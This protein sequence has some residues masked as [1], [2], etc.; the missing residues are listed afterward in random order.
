MLQSE[1]LGGFIQHHFYHESGAGF[2]QIELLVVIAIMIILASIGAVVGFDTIGRS[3]VA[4][5]RDLVVTL[6][7]SVRAKALANIN[8]LPQGLIIETDKITLFEGNSYAASNPLSRKVIKR[9]PNIVISGLKEVVFDQ[10]SGQALSGG[11]ITFSSP[12]ESATITLNNAGQ[13][14]W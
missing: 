4:S 8:E 3:T 7:S 13:I 9:N 5:E 6:L 12:N 1:K 14:D 2:T 10:L 11:I